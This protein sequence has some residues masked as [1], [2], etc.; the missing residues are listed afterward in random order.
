MKTTRLL[1]LTALTLAAGGWAHGFDPNKPLPRTEVVFFEPEK[2][3][4]I[5]DSAFGAWDAAKSEVLTE[6]RTYIIKEANRYLAQGQVLTVK[7][8]DVDL[9]GEF[10]PW[11]GAQWT[12]VRVVKDIYPPRIKLAFKL[13]GADGQVIKEGDRAL[14]DLAFNLR[15][16]LDRQD[17]RRYEK[18]LINDWLQQDFRGLK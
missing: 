16:T 18:E 17:P 11:R 3:S 9:A 7:I 2:F 5:R 13:V 10:E 6:L 15:L 4:D 8:T 12:D 14:S 1:L